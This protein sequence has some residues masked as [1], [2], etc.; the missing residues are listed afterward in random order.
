[1]TPFDRIGRPAVGDQTEQ[2][3]FQ[4]P[5]SL[6]LDRPDLYTQTAFAAPSMRDTNNSSGRMDFSPSNQDNQKL[7]EKNVIPAVEF[8]N[9]TYDSSNPQSASD[10]LVL[11]KSSRDAGYQQSPGEHSPGD[12]IGNT[13]AR[14]SGQELWRQSRHANLTEHGKFGCAAA[15]SVALNK[16]GYKW[17]DAATVG[18][19]ESQLRA[20]GWKRVPVDQAQDGDV[21]FGVNSKN[22]KNGGGHAHVGIMNNGLLYNNSKRNDARWTGESIDTALAVYPTRWALRPPARK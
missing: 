18:T 15:A 4:E 9:L 11:A 6:S 13:A 10:L 16:A 7:I 8:A 12:R 14:L 19:L 3:S 1:M 20:H 21:V 17:A 5:A 2:S 22:W